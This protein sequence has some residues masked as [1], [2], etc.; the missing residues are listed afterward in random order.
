MTFGKRLKELREKKGVTQ[1]DVSAAV[2][3]HVNQIRWYEY[4]NNEPSIMRAWWLADYFGVS[5][6]YLIGREQ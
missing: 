2:G 1:E 6:D 4:G 3:I 5:M